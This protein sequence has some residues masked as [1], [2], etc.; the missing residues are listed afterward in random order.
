MTRE[1]IF[2][3]TIDK[4]FRAWD[5][6]QNKFLFPWPEGFII[7]GETTC[8]DLI[9][10]QLK[11][12]TPEKNILTRLN[13]IIIS[14]FTG[15]KDKYRIEIYEGDILRNIRNDGKVSYYKVWFTEGGFVMNCHSDDFKK[16][17]E[18]IIF[19]EALADMQTRS[20]IA[21]QLEVI[22]NI[23]ENADLLK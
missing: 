19:T 14:Q 9:G 11:E 5:K 6:L 12:F 20:F 15:L 4:N 21:T 16:A 3:S 10:Q 23:F 8:F 7:L 13:D 1:D 2:E 18:N 22:G 17:F